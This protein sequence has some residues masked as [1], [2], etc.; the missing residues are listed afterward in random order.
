MCI[1]REHR[2]EGALCAGQRRQRTAPH[3]DDLGLTINDVGNAQLRGIYMSVKALFEA[4]PEDRQ[5]GK[6]LQHSTTC[7]ACRSSA[8]TAPI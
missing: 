4:Q 7:V 1:D 8:G 3:L 5:A 2:P 6:A